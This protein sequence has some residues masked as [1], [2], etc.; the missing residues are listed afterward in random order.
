[1]TL[2]A[3]VKNAVKALL[4]AE[5]VYYVMPFGGG[6]GRAGVADIIACVN[7][8]FIAIECKA[9]KGRTTAL[10]ERELGMVRLAGGVGIV[11]YE[12]LSAL[13]GWIHTLK[14]RSPHG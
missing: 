9:G 3:K 10:Q 7:G 2:E 11:V 5:H 8:Y 14:Q 1:M 12:D 6:Y 4:E 13:V